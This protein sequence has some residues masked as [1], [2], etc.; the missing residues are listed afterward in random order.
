MVEPVEGY[1]IREL[2]SESSTSPWEPQ[3][4]YLLAGFNAAQN[5]FNMGLPQYY[6]GA[7]IAGFDPATQAAQQGILGYSMGPRVAAQQAA[8]ENA[9]IKGL[10]GRI[11]PRAYDPMVNALTGNVIS[12]LQSNILPGIRQ[13]QVTYQPGGSSRGDL[14]NNRAISNA[15]NKGLTTPLADM[16]TNAY[17]LAQ[18]RQSQMAGLYPS[19]MNAPY[20]P[21]Q[22]MSQ[23]GAQR[24]A[25]S[26]SAFDRDRERYNYEAQAPQ[27]ALAN[28]M[29]MITGNYG[30]QTTAMNPYVFRLPQEPSGMDRFGSFLDSALKIKTLFGLSDRSIK[31]NIVPEG[32][33]WKGLNVYSFNYI[34]DSRKRRGVMAQ[35]VEVIRPDAVSNISGIKYVNYGVL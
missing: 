1:E 17:N 4:P 14:I 3:Q 19:I 27:Q 31:E 13:Q 8:A 33:K 24:Q 35:E 34:G 12:N 30:N 25:L 7:S 23:I 29:S 22:A 21:L 15:V 16:Y 26:Q 5:L 2:E 28:Y 9:L 32:A 20:A 11:D 18:Q 10:S 6:P